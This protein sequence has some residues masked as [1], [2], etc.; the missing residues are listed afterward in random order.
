MFIFYLIIKLFIWILLNKLNSFLFN[1]NSFFFVLLFLKC[2]CT[3]F[4]IY[5]VVCIVGIVLLSIRNFLF[6]RWG[7]T[8]RSINKL[9][10]V[11][12]LDF[13]SF[14][15]SFSVLLSHWHLSWGQVLLLHSFCCLAIFCIF[16]KNFQFFPLWTICKCVL[17]TC[18]FPSRLFF[19]ERV[20]VW[21]TWMFKSFWLSFVWFQFFCTVKLSSILL[22]DQWFTLL[23][24]PF[25]P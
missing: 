3:L 12:Q 2:I 1:I 24:S 9:R 25:L 10:I 20:I 4:F 7:H 23:T 8:I 6:V 15:C 17:F 21:S 13:C 16:L 11:S 22:V 14:L 5:R 18:I 19:D